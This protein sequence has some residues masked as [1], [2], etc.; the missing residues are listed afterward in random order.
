[1]TV[2][3]HAASWA[4]EVDGE[5]LV[6]DQGDRQ[7]DDTLAQASKHADSASSVSSVSV[8]T[9]T[10]NKIRSFTQRKLVMIF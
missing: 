4:N 8:T 9:T 5:R 10:T 1:V 6:A 7:R 3:V 2:L